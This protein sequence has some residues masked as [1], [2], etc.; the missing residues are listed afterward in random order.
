MLGA[1]LNALNPPFDSTG[2][3]TFGIGA[4]VYASLRFSPFISIPI[5]L[6]VSFPY[7]LT[8]GA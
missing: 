3:A 5:A 8:T 2:I 1:G 4:A 6:V 7:G